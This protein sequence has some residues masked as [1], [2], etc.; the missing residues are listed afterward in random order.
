LIAQAAAIYLRRGRS[1]AA[2]YADRGL[3][4]GDLIAG[5]SDIDLVAV[6]PDDPAGALQEHLRLRRRWERARR[7]A[8]LV[9]GRLIA[10]MA[11]YE[12]GELRSA[13]DAS[14]L[15]AGLRDGGVGASSAVLFGTDPPH[16][17]VQLRA[18]PGLV[19]P[20]A[21]WRL[22]SGAERRPPLALRG[23]QELRIAAWLELQFWWRI[24]FKA[25]AD[26]AKPWTAYSCV[27]MVS[28]PARI[29]LALIDEPADESRAETLARASA[30]LPQMADA[31]SEAR[32]LLRV[33]PLSPKPPL[34]RFLGHLISF[35]ELI[36]ERLVAEVEP[37]GLTRVQLAGHPDELALPGGQV[38]RGMLPL[39]DWRAAAVPSLPDEAVLPSRGL[40]AERLI[41]CTAPR[42]PAVYHAVRGR[43]LIALPVP[44]LWQRGILRGVQMPLSDPVSFAQA[45]GSEAAA[46]PEVAGW[47]A[48]DWARRALAEHKA[49]LARHPEDQLGPPTAR[50]WLDGEASGAAP[51]TRAVAKL[52]T[53]ARAAL[54]YESLRAGRPELPL[55]VAATCDL[56]GE[57]DR[58][59]AESVAR[60]ARD[61]YRAARADDDADAAEDVL[62]PLRAVVLGLPAYAGVASAG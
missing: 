39:L 5:L 55:T 49:W 47:S 17:D 61:A 19:G 10:D 43:N 14:I 2:V 34:R 21:G 38:S 22:I 36:A 24:A 6:V 56:L 32:E 16:D 58:R 13:V 25:I 37:A 40:T 29:W 60:E 28:E 30:H 42:S 44:D 50:E 53:A 31:I 11:I 45:D 57:V 1:Q 41:E 3:G 4:S 51:A 18:R 12:D 26:P 7:F 59:D 9:A 20:T 33:L 48:R 8:P 27:K 52:L 46:F 23:R 35:S 62:A 15:T 54:F